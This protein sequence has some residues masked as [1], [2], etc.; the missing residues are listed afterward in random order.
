[1]S[2]NVTCVRASDPFTMPRIPDN[3]LE[4]S[5]RSLILRV[6]HSIEKKNF[7]YSSANSVV[8]LGVISNLSTYIRTY[9]KEK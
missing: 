8:N 9:I 7:T 6:T 1:M 5:C 4:R 3:V 2:H